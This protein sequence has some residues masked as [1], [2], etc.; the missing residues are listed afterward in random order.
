VTKDK[1]YDGPV[2]FV[3]GVHYPATVEDERDGEDGLHPDMSRP[4]RFDV[5]AG[6]YRDAADGE[7]L[8]NDV[9]HASDLVF[10]EA[11]GGEQ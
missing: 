7:P 1:L 3:D 6:M 10:D 8:H 11:L 4:L 5:D 2:A 9:H